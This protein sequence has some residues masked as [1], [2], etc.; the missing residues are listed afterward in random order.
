MGV[1]V[2]TTTIGSVVIVESTVTTGSVEVVF[3]T[4]VIIGSM[5]TIPPAS[6]IVTVETG[7]PYTVG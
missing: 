3:V 6:I 7:Q 5:T 2:S 4:G 1:T